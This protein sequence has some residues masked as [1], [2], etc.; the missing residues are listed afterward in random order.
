MSV[1]RRFGL[2]ALPVAVGRIDDA[3]TA[4]GRDPSAIR[5]VYNISGTIQSAADG[6]FRGPVAQWSETI[7]ELV[8][9]VGMN[10]FVIWPE[11]DHAEQ[12]RAFAAEVVPAVRETLGQL[13]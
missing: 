1:Q 9:T 12:I 4:A 6:P 3:A 7:A 13:D 10:G 2:D 8:T 5:K 11:R